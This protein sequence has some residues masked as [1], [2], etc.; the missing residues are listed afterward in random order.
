LI[1]IFIYVTARF[2][3]SFALGGFGAILHDVIISV[4]IV[5]LLGRELSLIHVG[6]ILTIAGYSINDTIVVFDR[7][8]EN[9]GLSRRITFQEIINRSVNQTLSRTILTAGTTLLAVLSLFF[10]GGTVIH[11]FAI[12]MLMGV[13]VGTYSS[14][15]VASALALDLSNWW[16]RRK[17]ARASR[18]PAKAAASS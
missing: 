11:D 13:L 7:I 18:T 10:L 8:R 2:E 1:G 6:A 9:L 15:F 3:F 16:N 17:E 4:G 12:A 14:I 5:V